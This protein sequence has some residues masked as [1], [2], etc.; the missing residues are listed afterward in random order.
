MDPRACGATAFLALAVGIA[1]GVVAVPVQEA[2]LVAA[3]A[4]EG[5]RF[6]NSVAVA[7]DTVVV[8]AHHE[9]TG[10]THR[11]AAYV[12]TKTGSTWTQ[13]AKL[14]AADAANGDEFGYSVAL[15][16]DTAVVGA[17]SKSAYRGAAYV[18]TRTGTT[19][20]QQ[21]N[22]TPS[23]AADR[24]QFGISVA[25][26]G[27]TAVVGTAYKDFD[28]GAAY[29]FTRAGTTWSQQAKLTAADSA[30]RDDFGISVAIA[31]DT[32]VIGASNKNSSQGAAYAFTRSGTTWTQQ[33]KLMAADAATN[34]SFGYAVTVVG[35][36]AV[37]GAYGQS[38]AQ[39]AAYVFTRT[40]SAWTQQAKLT[41]ADGTSN[42][43]FAQTVALSGDTVV[44][45]SPVNNAGLSA[46][47]AFTRTG[48][49]WTQAAEF[50]AADATYS[51]FFGAAVALSG[52]T[53]VVGAFYKTR[54][55][56]VAYVFDLSAA[57]GPP[58]GYCLPT[59]VKVKINSAHV[60]KSTLAASGTLDTG[61]GA[62]DFS[63]AATF[64]VAG[65]RLLV[66]AFVPKGRSLTYGAR[67]VALKITPAKNGSSHAAFSVKVVGDAR[68][69]VELDEPVAFNFSNRV[70][71]LSGTAKLTAD[72]LGPHGVTSPG[73]AI[74]AA[75]ATIKGG[76]KDALK[77]TL[78]FATDGVVPG[79]AEDLT[80]NF[81]ATYTS[82]L[83]PAASFV[84]KG[85]AWVRTA[86]A[87]GIA[88]A[89]VDYVKGTIA[90][91]GKGLDL[92]AFATGGNAV[93]VTVTRGA[94]TRSAA[95]RMALAGTKL[96]Y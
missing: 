23:D 87:P 16:G 85:N 48:N 32:A 72:T 34:D 7:G 4:A 20:T 68:G 58:P 93:V 77:L 47:Y 73:L 38:A 53:A 95:V 65:F 55:Q 50:T 79:A 30:S 31:G 41:A 89:T 63:G 27:D 59:K 35:D 92:G 57:G 90:I 81:G 80:I 83:L 49:T 45:G 96:T 8:G 13:Q 22:L 56:G 61:P 67:G 42:E 14:T 94:D 2:K 39:G 88:K 51:D 19:W 74:L 91:A 40:G 62:P 9:S 78:S 10:G 33:A 76:G 52:D 54:E 36:T 29:V 44:A 26:A 82:T 46:A 43:G 17:Y 5:D 70:H 69:R 11:G 28:R 24:D 86:K 66:P 21:A 6:G 12:F 71:N 3:D 75:A 25:L 60:Q 64:D 1:F 18:F 37:V 84:R 15:E